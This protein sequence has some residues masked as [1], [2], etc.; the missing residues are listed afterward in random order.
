MG[1]RWHNASVRENDHGKVTSRTHRACISL[2]GVDV[3]LRSGPA[4]AREARARILTLQSHS[5]STVTTSP[6]TTIRCLKLY[7]GKEAAPRST[8]RG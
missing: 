7:S 2:K 6:C 8:I 5:D 3:K 4:I 1:E